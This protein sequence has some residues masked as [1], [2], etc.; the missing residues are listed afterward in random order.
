[1]GHKVEDQMQKRFVFMIKWGLSGAWEVQVKSLLLV[2]ISMGVWGNVLRVLKVYTGNAIGKRN[3][4]GRRLLEFCDE[5]E[6]C[7]ANTCFYKKEKRKITYSGGGCETEIDFVLVGEKCRKYIRDVKVIPWE[8]QHS[9]VVV[10]LDKKVLK[11]IVRTQR[12]I[13]RKIWKLN[14]NQTR[15]KFEKRVKEPVSTD[16]PDLWKTFKDGVLKACDEVCG[17]KKS[18]RDQGRHVVVE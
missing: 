7:V 9:L 12:I 1:M 5:R 18:R 14:E 15:V 10:D 4:E 6:L 11:K 17:K 2:G 13:R 3:V 8:I 16:A